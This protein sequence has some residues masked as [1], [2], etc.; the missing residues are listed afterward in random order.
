[1]KKVA[2]CFFTGIF[3]FLTGLFSQL[4]AQNQLQGSLITAEGA[5]L[6]FAN[7]LLLQAV[8]STLIKGQITDD[9]GRFSL[10]NIQ[11]GNYF[12]TFNML[13]YETVQTESFTLTDQPGLKDVGETTLQ[14]SAAEL[15]AVEVIGKKPLFEQK[16]DRLVVNV[17]NTITSAGG[18]AL[19]VLERSPGVIVNRQNNSISISGKS[20]VVVMINGRI[21]YMSSEAVVQLLAGISSDNIEKIELITTP[22]A[23]FDAEGNAGFINIVLKKNL[24]D[25]MS[26]SYSLSAGYG[27]GETANASINFNYRKG[28]FNLYG[29]YSHLRNARAQVF[30]FDRSIQLDNEFVETQT[31]SE[32]DPVQSNHN[33]RLGMD[34]QLSKNTIIG[35]LF[36]AYDTKWT[37]DALNKAMI[38]SNGAPES[39]INI[40]NEELN[41]WRH[42]GGNFNV[43]HTFREGET[44]NFDADYLYYR[45][46]NPT[47]YLNSYLDGEG[48][49]EFDE[50]TRSRKLTPI[51]VAVGKMDYSRSLTEKVKMTTGLKATF[52]SFTNDVAVERWM[53]QNWEAD[54]GLT[55]KYELHEKIFAAYGDMD[56]SLG[57][58][59]TMKVGLRYEY[60]DSNLGAVEQKDIVDRQYGRFFPSFFLSRQINENNAVNFS[61]SRR[62]TRPTFNDMA[63]FVIFMD[64]TTFFS[65]N[66]ALQPA[67]SN[68]VKLDYQVKSM[69]FSA[70]YSREDST[71]ARFQST[72]I[73]GTNQQL[74]F[75][76]N[77]KF[78]NTASFTA[79]IPFSP[80]KWWNMYI[81]ASGVWEQI[82]V[83]RDGMLEKVELK[84]VNVFSSQTFI[85][86]KN[87][88]LEVNGFFNS[89]SLFGAFKVKPFGAVNAGLQKKFG[90]HGGTLRLGYDNIFNTLLF[91]FSSDVPA[92]GQRFGG[93]L[94]FT[95]PTIKISYSRNFGNRKMK[96]QRK[97][98]TGS[99][100]ERQRVD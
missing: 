53:T 11:P 33:G 97:R 16:V 32:R 61:Y 71:I 99:E 89:G 47:D 66:P 49:F 90:E 81:N 80:V 25:G 56:W 73:P 74:I 96:S 48:S 9:D 76:E 44:L 27:K 30:A 67:F 15:E 51:K 92:L 70:Q 41:Q 84:S 88:S 59:T 23:G 46:N 3:L 43:K 24:D 6:A 39:Q 52:S 18:T 86:P 1:M 60:T 7:V 58:K 78:K 19:E 62:I 20:G 57:E 38:S 36:S 17:A 31:R 13:G 69:L 100:E 94:Q 28:I 54:P 68:N 12:M 82:G 10:E 2:N 95:Q 50:R 34:L 55:N 5:P 35:A 83:N 42:Y 22:P 21:N 29:D 45:D 63:P 40:E 64:P 91:R 26:G 4:Q 75:A 79:S 93:E 98:A 72:V 8:D 37:M 85:L 14:E 77:L 65:G 87:F